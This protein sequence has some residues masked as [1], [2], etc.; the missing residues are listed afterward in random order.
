M[1]PRRIL[2]LSKRR[3]MG[4]D[5]IGDRYGRFREI[6]LELARLGHDVRG[7]AFGYRGEAEGET[8]DEGVRW[9]SVGLGRTVLPGIL[10]HWQA[11]REEARAFRPDVVLAVSDAFHAIRGTALA[12]SIGAR[13]VV[14]LYDNFES[15]A[16]TRVPPVFGLFRQA[17]RRADLVTCISPPLARHVAARYGRTGPT[18]VL[19][20]AVRAD[21]FSPGDRAGAR[22][23]FG[24]PEDVRLVGL[25]GSISEDRDVATLFRAM[26][27]LAGEGAPVGLV[28]AGPRGPGLAWPSRARVFDL[29][30]IDHA[31]VPD[32]IRAAD[33]MV[34]PNRAS[35][36]GDFCHPQKACEA[37]ACGVPVVAAATGSVAEFLGGFPDSLYT[38]GDAGDLARVLRRRLEGTPDPQAAEVHDWRA[39]AGMLDRWL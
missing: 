7:V 25:A 2:V 28:A 22:R 29:G 20:N 23:R 13:S 3:Y 8:V 9:R 16:G 10:R 39:I 32:V 11:I 24:L 6:P 1:P 33:V 35:A 37:L 15:Y 36:F 17:V 18:E 31:A 5:L 26:D 38:V 34:V 14:D 19:P 21:L 30:Q 4:R 12:R 27:L